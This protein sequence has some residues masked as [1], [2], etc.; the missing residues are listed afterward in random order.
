MF[1]FECVCVWGGGGSFLSQNVTLL[2][3]ANPTL[4]HQS[5]AGRAQPGGHLT[6]QANWNLPL[7]AF[8]AG[9][10]PFP[11]SPVW[12]S[13]PTRISPT[14]PFSLYILLE[15][16]TFYRKTACHSTLCLKHRKM[17][18]SDLWLAHS[19]T[20][21]ALEEV[22]LTH[23]GWSGNI[24][25]KFHKLM[26]YVFRNILVPIF[27]VKVKYKMLEFSVIGTE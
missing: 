27:M 2:A 13:F 1:E 10:S 22:L 26:R 4:I 17:E 14:F 15:E 23:L 18:G 6:T 25:L 21:T 16:E 7:K 8:S 11:V 3:C 12:G 5:W 24:S 19:S 20:P 9:N